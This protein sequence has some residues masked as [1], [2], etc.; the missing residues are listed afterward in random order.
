MGIR[1]RVV[2]PTA[3][4]GLIADRGY[5]VKVIITRPNSPILPCDEPAASP[6]VCQDRFVYAD[7]A[8]VR[9]ANHEKV[10]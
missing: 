8:V 9:A 4:V 7:S 6:P 5:P 10:I 1:V 3:R 2:Q